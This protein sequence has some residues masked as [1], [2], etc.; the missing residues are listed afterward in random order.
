MTGG[1]GRTGKL[2]VEKLVANKDKF[3]PRAVV[4]GEQVRR[5]EHGSFSTFCHDNR[6]APHSVLQQPLMKQDE[7]LDVN[8]AKYKMLKHQCLQMWHALQ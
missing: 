6:L 4:R 7:S 2:V 3:E 5:H 8:P 1:A